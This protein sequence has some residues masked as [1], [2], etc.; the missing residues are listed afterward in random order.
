LRQPE[1]PF[2]ALRLLKDDVHDAGNVRGGVDEPQRVCAP[3]SGAAALPGL[4]LIAV[5]LLLVA[6]VWTLVQ[7]WRTGDTG[8]RFRDRPGSP[9][10][11]AR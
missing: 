2:D 9:Q 6:Y 4:V 7:I 11:W 10:W 8:V 1:R 5:W 3:G